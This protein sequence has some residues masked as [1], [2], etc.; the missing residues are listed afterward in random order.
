VVNLYGDFLTIIGDFRRAEAMERLAVELD[1][2]A[3]VQHSDLASLLLALH[4]PEEALESARTSA[5][6][7]P[8]LP[9]RQRPLIIAL[10]LLGRFDEAQGL[11]EQFSEEAGAIGDHS[12]YWRGML[13]M[14][15][16]DREA[17]RAVLA[18]QAG[19]EGSGDDYLNYTDAAFLTAWADGVAAA[20]PLLQKAYET[21]EYQLTW[22]EYFYLPE[23]VSTDPD[24]L[25]FWEQPRLAGLVALR[26]ANHPD[27]A[28]GY[29]KA[30]GEP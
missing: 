17:V 20:L 8:G 15:R 4:R 1:P 2:L 19:K 10:I 9:A 28:V 22:P 18:A 12:S 30:E 16:G 13:A 11:I 24:W 26:R 5:R 25:A 29:W 14:Y 3:A 27:T 21:Q 6:L 23:G 7:E